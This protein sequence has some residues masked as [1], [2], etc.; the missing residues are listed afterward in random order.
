LSAPLTTK[1]TIPNAEE[2]TTGDE[3]VSPE[4]HCQLLQELEKMDEYTSL[5]RLRTTE[6]MGGEKT[7]NDIVIAWVV[8]PTAAVTVRL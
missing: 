2:H 3:T 4:S 5:F 1:S 6:N 7:T 8:C